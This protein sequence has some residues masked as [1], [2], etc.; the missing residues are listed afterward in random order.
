MILSLTKALMAWIFLSLPICSLYAQNQVAINPSKHIWATTPAKR[1]YESSPL[2]NGRL[3][4][5]LFGGTKTDR[6]VLNESTMW[7]GS[8]MDGDN[9][10]AHTFLPEIQ[11]LLLEGKNGAAQSILQRN[12]V[13][14]GPGSSFGNAKDAPFGCYQILADLI[15][16]HDQEIDHLNYRRILDLDTAIASITSTNKVGITREGFTSAPANVFVYKLKGSAENPL[17]FNVRLSR[18][19]RREIQYSLKDQPTAQISGELNSGNPKIEGVKYF[20]QLKIVNLGGKVSATENGLRVTNANE[21]I[22]YFSAATSMFDSQYR[23]TTETNVK[24][25]VKKGFSTLKRQHISDYQSYARRSELKL[26]EGKPA[27]LPTIE[28]LAAV[29]KGEQDPSL[30]ALYYHYGRYLLISS[31]RPNSPLPANLQGI[32]AEEYQT[33]WNSDFHLNIN[34]Q[35]N[36]WLAET[37]NL[38]DCAQPLLNFIPKLMPNGAKTA[39]AYY[40]ARGWVAHVITNPWLFT[41]PGEGAN[42][43]S[44]LSGGAWLTAHQWEHYAF[45]NNKNYLKSAYPSLRE[46]AR[47][48]ADMLVEEKHGWLVTAPSNSPEN[49]FQHPTDGPV[50]T[51]MGPTMDQQIVRELFTNVINASKI[52][53]TDEEFRKELEDKLKR[54]APMQ[55]NKEGRLQEWLEDYAEVEVTH[56]HVSHLYGLHPS[57]QID[58]LTTPKLAD[59]ARKSLERRGDDGTGWSLAWKVCFWARLRDGNH[60]EKVLNRLLRPT[61]TDG[62]NYSNGGGTYANLFDAHPPFQ[63]DGNFGATAGIAEMLLQSQSGKI[64]LLP[65]LPDAWK[66]KG[67]VTGLRARGGKRVNIEWQNGVITHSKIY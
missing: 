35:M 38:Q 33:P 25:A 17:N 30:A 44:T 60:A 53:N 57:N 48:F 65:A 41:S 6:I 52:L 63:I 24:S 47:F 59:A 28:R 42:W 45:S 19:E 1:F 58:P 54:L 36:Y 56:R 11:K 15:I 5:M 27:L 26:P 29:A 13:C 10:N 2:G 20:G 3:G 50:N 16:E 43:G 23:Q 55:I 64:E 7:S 61:G 34:V 14:K 12:F 67:S 66:S 9:E 18:N 51:C 32:W 21:V 49:A 39:K 62:F 31:S 46:S 8:P 4:A 22:F 37:T 40:N